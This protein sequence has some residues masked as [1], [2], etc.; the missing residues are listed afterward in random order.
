[1]RLAYAQHVYPQQGATVDHAIMLTGGWQTSKES[2]YVQA[3][4]ARHG[5]DW[6]LARDQLGH[7]GQ[8]S[9]RITR[10]AHH[11]TTSRAH[12]PSITY[13][14]TWDPTL[15]PLHEH[16]RTLPFDLPERDQERNAAEHELEIGYER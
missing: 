5:T 13:E 14:E 10:L 6:Y 4:R 12:Q 2:A 7:E 16:E 15:D 3:S 1:L 11:M 8:D 9:D